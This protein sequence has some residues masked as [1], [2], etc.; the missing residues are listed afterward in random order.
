[1]NRDTSRDGLR[2][3]AEYYALT[4]FGPL[5]RLAQR[6]PALER[7]VN[8]ALVNSAVLK[9][10]TRPHPTSLK[11]E[12]TSW[13][14][15]TDRT[16]SGRHLPPAQAGYTSSL[17]PASEVAQAFLRPAGQQ[18]LSSTS[19]LLL[20]HF[21]QWFTDGFLRTDRN[22]F[23]KNTS[24]N[25]IDLSPVYGVTPS[26][27]EGLRAFTG[28][29]LKSQ[30]IDG[31][32]F[33][34][35]YFDDN[36]QAK[37]EF[38]GVPLFVPPDLPEERRKRLF[39]SGVERANVQIGFVMFNVLCL[40]EHNRLCRE[41][42]AAHPGWDDERLFQTA[43]NTM[44]AMVLKL[45]IEE[46]INHIAP[47]HFKF[48]AQPRSF[49]QSSWYRTN[50]MTVEF[51]LLYRWHGL[52]TDTVLVGD[53]D[54]DVVDTL[55]N[56]QLL[57]ERG[58]GASFD[59]ASRHPC[60]R[61]G[62]RNTHHSLLRTEI[63]SIEHGRRANLQPY[64]AYR[65]YCGYPPVTRFEQITGDQERQRLLKELYKEPDRVELYTGLFAE[66]P[67]SGSPLSPLI[68]R[69]V[70]ID[71]FSQALTNPLLSEHV[72]H[73]GT[74]GK[75][76]WD[77]LCNTSALSQIVNRNLQSEAVTPHVGFDLRSAGH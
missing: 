28:G 58:L 32:E 49:Y 2:N 52:V 54:I 14:S 42:Q 76:G 12:Y 25:E 55:F 31:S 23:R 59:D 69:M 19:T 43:R 22:D 74:F 8:R 39:A 15:L 33:P 60:G 3:K 75:I 7:I 53:A 27:T 36:G 18:R 6:V 16:F 68:G 26:I 30:M 50:W 47:Y 73:E 1:M 9:T 61:I 21:A 41:F 63:A 45:V 46:Y 67:R 70:G 24:N 5:W 71:A 29:L 11:F 40:R 66:D 4:H 48:R 72:F 34:P 13:C 57:I 65:A 51:N 44:I 64:N 56:N 62:L 37:P 20:S 17:P 10:R 35:F 77:T 38:A